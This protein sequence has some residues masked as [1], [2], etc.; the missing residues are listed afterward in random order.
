M[1]TINLLPPEAKRELRLE[2]WRRAV[3]LIGAGTTAVLIVGTA[4][5]APSYLYPALQRG[6]LE[7]RLAIEGQRTEAMRLD[8]A[9]RQSREIETLI[10]AV[11]ASRI[12]TSGRIFRTIVRETT[13]G[14]R[15]TSFAIQNRTETTL[16]G[17]AQ[18]RED[19]LAFE[20]TLR[21]SGA[22]EEIVSPLSDIIRDANINF[23][24]RGKLT[25]AYAP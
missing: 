25:S 23:S 11:R 15:I 4:L 12:G 9:A 14:I 5:L 13:A 1:L 8:E 20:K 22:F 10:Q 6:E 2:E 19:L 17:V 21:D 16:T 3:A 18:T 24:M 7:R